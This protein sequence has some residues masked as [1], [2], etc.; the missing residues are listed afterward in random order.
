MHASPAV[1][2]RELACRQISVSEELVRAV[3]IEMLKES[4]RLSAYRAALPR[5][6]A[7]SMRHRPQKKPPR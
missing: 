7:A 2:V 1:V 4:N 6:G 5:G 3:R